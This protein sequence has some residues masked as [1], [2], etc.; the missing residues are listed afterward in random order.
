MISLF[1]SHEK[2]VLHENCIRRERERERER[3]RREREG[4]GEKEL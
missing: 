4:E 1:N 2:S 3:E